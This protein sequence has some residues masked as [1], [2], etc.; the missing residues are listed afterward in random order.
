MLKRIIS[1][2]NVGRFSDLKAE[3]G[4]QGEFAKLNVIFAR[5]GDGKSTLCDIFRSLAQNNAT[6]VVGR[7]R[8]GSD[9]ASKVEFLL[10]GSVSYKAEFSPQGWTTQPPQ[11]GQPKI[12]IYD[13]R[14]VMENVLIGHQIEA[15]QRRSLFGL[16]IGAQAIALE[17]RVARAGETQKAATA[18]LAAA[19]A[20]AK[21]LLP[22][23][24]ALEAWRK[25]SAVDHVEELI[26]A[27]E[28]QHKSATTAGANAAAIKARSLLAIPVL[29]LVPADLIDVLTTSLEGTTASAM[30]AV[31]T[32]LDKHRGIDLDW[33]KKGFE[34]GEAKECPYC[35]QDV[36]DSEQVQ[37]Y[38]R[39]FNEALRKQHQ[40]LIEIET[41]M[42]TAFGGVSRI[43]LRQVFDKHGSEQ[44]WWKDTGGLSVGLD[45]QVNVDQLIQRMEEV[46]AVVL[47]AVKRKRENPNQSITLDDSDVQV[48]DAWREYADSI[49]PY[50][51]SLAQANVAIRNH[52]LSIVSSDVGQMAKEIDQLK[53]TQA[54]HTA[55]A[56]AVISQLDRAEKA[57]RAADKEKTDANAALKD[58]SNKIFREYG[59]R[60]NQNLERYGVAFRI[61][62]TGVNFSGGQPS[63]E[64][65][66]EL[67][68]NEISTNAADAMN[69]SKPSLVN[70]LSSGDR[71]TLAL[72]YFLAVLDTQDK[73]NTVVVF[74]DPFHRQDSARKT[75]TIESIRGVA[76]SFG[77]TFVLSHD[78]DFARDVERV[79]VDGVRTF[80]LFH[81]DKSILK[82]HDLPSLAAQPHIKDYGTLE[83]FAASPSNDDE[84]C[85]TVVRAIR[86]AL[87]GYFRVKYPSQFKNNEWLGDMIGKIRQAPSDSP[88][89]G[90]KSKVESL[91]EVNNYS[92]KH[93]HSDATDDP[94]DPGELLTYTKQALRIIHE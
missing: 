72:A 51:E 58:E 20:R 34:S 22:V 88:L 5:N 57:K 73:A 64:V 37:L 4:T 47:N 1:I 83:K 67:L 71:S 65:V 26:R 15:G 27:K 59:E 68:N 19:E 81:T 75:R 63:G 54:R 46:E 85:R 23:G 94:I 62:Q 30:D 92:K 14:F 55:N 21:A 16:V 70:T 44:Q 61:K 43:T 33:L 56:T 84:C 25:L 31:K 87:E 50:L 28:D 78:L 11:S 29:P 6:Y 7:K 10:N 41:T 76:S 93:H 42:S 48:L 49:K 79:Q 13:E 82:Q 12:M 18:D 45:S 52:Q 36:T 60:I 32:H 69:P 2:Q 17:D 90:S 38:A 86:P 91:D 80:A 89:E 24:W 53:A 39:V 66:L 77:Q 8:F 35:A 9:A 74:D 3:S 40:R